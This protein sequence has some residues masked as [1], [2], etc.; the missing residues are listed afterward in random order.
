M[1]TLLDFLSIGKQLDELYEFLKKVKS[2]ISEYSRELS[3]KEIK[4]VLKDFKKGVA[5][6]HIICIKI[7]EADEVEKQMLGKS[8]NISKK[9]REEIGQKIGLIAQEL[10]RIVKIPAVD[11]FIGERPVLSKQMYRT[12]KMRAMVKRVWFEEAESLKAIPDEELYDRK[13]RIKNDPTYDIEHAL[14]ILFIKHMKQ[15]DRSAVELIKVLDTTI[16]SL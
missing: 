8:L 10:E 11:H 16:D 6:T 5:E 3:N 14:Q 2:D 12:M 15:L 7:I 13:I 4:Q 1:T 9:E